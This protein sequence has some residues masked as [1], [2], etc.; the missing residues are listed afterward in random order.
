MSTYN[1]IQV[2]VKQNHG[3]IPK[4]CWIADVKEKSDIYVE[5]AWNRVGEERRNPC[6]PGKFKAI[7]DGLKH[8]GII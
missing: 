5:P 8:F 6:P 3:F 7:Q 2:Y 1:K 4:T